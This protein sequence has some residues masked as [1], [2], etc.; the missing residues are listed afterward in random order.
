[1]EF[2][3]MRVEDDMQLTTPLGVGQ[4]ADPIAKP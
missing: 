4:D 1:M 2:D 3:S